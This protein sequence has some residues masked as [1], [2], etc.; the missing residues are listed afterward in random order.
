[1]TRN[2]LDVGAFRNVSLDAEHAIA[3]CS[4]NVCSHTGDL[5]LQVEGNDLCTLLTQRPGEPG[6]Q[7]LS[8]P[9]DDRNFSIK[10]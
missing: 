6:T 2:L 3:R 10:C 7:S 1:M 9:T 4:L 5:I 8:R